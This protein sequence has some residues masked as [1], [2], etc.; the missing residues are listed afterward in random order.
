MYLFAEKIP[1]R[2]LDRLK[3]ILPAYAGR[4]T[5]VS[6]YNTGTV[7]VEISFVY[8]DDFDSYRLHKTHYKYPHPTRWQRFKK[9]I[10]NLYV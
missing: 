6:H 2:E 5:N 9:L 10:R 8:K 4:I 7:R 1:E 3:L